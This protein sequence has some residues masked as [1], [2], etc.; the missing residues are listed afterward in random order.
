M[1]AAKCSRFWLYAVLLFFMA[2][3]PGFLWFYQQVPVEGDF[4]DAGVK[5]DAIIVLTGGMGRVEQ[6]IRLLQD[7]RAAVLLISGVDKDVRPH[8]IVAQY[9]VDVR[10]PALAEGKARIMLD[11]GPRDTVGNAQETTRIMREQGWRSMRLVTSGYHMPRS[12]MEFRHAMP[13]A[14]ILPSPVFVDRESLKEVALVRRGAL[15]LILIE[16]HK[17][18]FRRAYYMLPPKLQLLASRTST[19]RPVTDIVLTAPA[20]LDKNAAPEEKPA[21]EKASVE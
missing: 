11:Y 20:N 16:Y 18:L 19:L 5:T 14:I 4:P 13:E 15:R 17:Y 10:H 8:E 1:A 21:P 12:V 6:G 2:W 7:E 3:A 9:G